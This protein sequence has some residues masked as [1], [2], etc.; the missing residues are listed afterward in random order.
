MEMKE[1]AGR[2]LDGVIEAQRLTLLVVENQDRPTRVNSIRIEGAQYTRGTVIERLVKPILQSQN[3]GDVISESREACQRLRRLGVFRDVGVTLDTA[4]GRGDAVDVVLTVNE[5]PRVYARQAVDVGNYEG[6]MNLTLKLSNLSGT[7]ESFEMN[8]AYGLE[9]S[10]PLHKDSDPPF[11]S[12]TGTSFQL[13][14]GKP[15]L[16]APRFGKAAHS[17]SDARV[18]VGVSKTNRNLSLFASHE[19]KVQGIAARYKVSNPLDGSHV[20]SYNLDWRQVHS[21]AKEAS[22]S[23]RKDGGH[24]LKSAVS[25]TFTRDRRDD[26]MLPTQG[27][28]V[29]T[30]QE[31]AGLGGDVQF[32]K[33]EVEGQYAFPLG[34]GFSVTSSLRAGLV[35][36]WKGQ[37]TRINDR[38][39]LGGPLTIR[40]FRQSG[41]GPKDHADTVGGDAFWAAGLS[42]FTPL[43]YLVDKPIKGHLFVNG[44]SLIPVDTTKATQE[45]VRDLI[46]SPSVSTGLGLAVRFS[47]LRLELNWCLPLIASQSDAV[48]PGLQFGIGLNY[49]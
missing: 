8:A 2:N 6:N 18:E 40:G 3:L 46:R 20:F 15:V 27:H 28:Y 25:H 22:W 29:K 44:G 32:A 36:P 38:F 9:T 42:L 30:T 5:G 13:L 48:K 43:P 11:A 41:I 31:I 4:G 47:I 17:E 16:P 14:F 39:T 12:Q 21:I 26:P 7:G 34:L 10:V 37:G 35:L 49:M 1:E 24:S 19:E 33:G 23:V 45:T